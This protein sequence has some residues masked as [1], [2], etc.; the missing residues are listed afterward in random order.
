M[1]RFTTKQKRALAALLFVLQEGRCAYC[2]KFVRLSYWP[3][4]RQRHDAGMLEH[5]RR[6]AD[7]GRDSKDNLALVCKTC[8]DSRGVIDWLLYTSW[9]RDEF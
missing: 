4:D 5:L 9:I 1:R 2:R 7:G 6:R 3:P 8:T